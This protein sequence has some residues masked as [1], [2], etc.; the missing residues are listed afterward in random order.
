MPASQVVLVT[1]A[2]SGIGRAT[3]DRL[4][5]RGYRVFASA[6]REESVRE[7]A[8]AGRDKGFEAVRLDV[9]DDASTDRAMAEINDRAGSVDVL[10]NNA[11]YGLIAPTEAV[12]P[13]ALRA[14]FETNVIGAHRMVRAVLPGMRARKR[15][16][17]VQ[18]SSVMGRVVFPLYG[19]Y[20]ASKFALEAMSDALR[21]EVAA[22]GIRVVLVEP[23]PIRTEFSNT[24]HRLSTP[25]LD[26]DRARPY[27]SIIA[28]MTRA[29]E[30]SRNAGG[31]GPDAVAIVIERA[32]ASRAPAP[33][34]AVT[35]LAKLAPHFKDVLPDRL[36]DGI[37]R[38]YFAR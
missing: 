6:R 10:V 17:I 18:L 33:R 24:V 1:G 11:G 30:Q 29:R 22:F 31:L 36:F 14:Q 15:G 32:I 21:I 27:A 20:S 38:R 9:E 13:E 25:A 23:G 3:V 26:D 7:L 8:K 19:A 28:K 16:T 4:A 12:T 34:Y 2:S 5:A 35:A 37:L